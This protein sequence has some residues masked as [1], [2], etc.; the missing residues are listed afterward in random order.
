VVRGAPARFDPREQ[1]Q[2]CKRCG[3]VDGFNFHVPDEL[4]ARVVPDPLRNRVVCLACF[5]DL[6]EAAGVEYAHVLSEVCFAGQ[7][8]G[9]LFAVVR[10]GVSTPSDNPKGSPLGAIPPRARTQ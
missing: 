3:A 8:C 9:V 7:R 6:A 5:D 10:T 1:R 2:S 4:W